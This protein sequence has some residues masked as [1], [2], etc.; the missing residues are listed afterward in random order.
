MPRAALQVH[1]LDVGTGGLLLV[2]KTRAAAA[3][4]SA[5]LARHNMQKR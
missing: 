5:D 1:R 2:A 3:Q 4:L